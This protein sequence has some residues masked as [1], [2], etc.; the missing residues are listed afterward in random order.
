MCRFLFFASAPPF[1]FWLLPLYF[2]PRAINAE[3]V[4]VAERTEG[5]RV[6]G[7]RGTGDAL[8]VVG[9]D[10]FE[11]AEDLVGRDVA[12]VYDLLAREC[13]GACARR[14]ETQEDRRDGLIF[15]KAQLVCA[16]VDADDAAQFGEREIEH[17]INLRGRRAGVDLKDAD[18]GVVRR[19]RADRIG[20]A[21]FLT[22]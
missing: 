3:A 22:N 6:R 18:I 2:Q 19:R 4:Q 15:R 13:A 8:Q 5:E 10:G 12:A 11:A 14:F 7:E 21:A 16:D 9:R 1:L 20:E 17:F